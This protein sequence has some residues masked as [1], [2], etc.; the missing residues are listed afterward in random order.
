MRLSQGNDGNLLLPIPY[1]LLP[2]SYSLFPIPYY[3]F[4]IPYLLDRE[5]PV[6][7]IHEAGVGGFVLFSRTA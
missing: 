1:Y 7:G 6:V 5:I 4:S 2:I 3:L